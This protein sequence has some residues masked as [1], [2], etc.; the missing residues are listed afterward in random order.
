M[1]QFLIS[2]SICCLMAFCQ[3]ISADGGGKELPVGTN[4]VDW[5]LA[6]P[7]NALGPIPSNAAWRQDGDAFLGEGSAA[8]WS[9][10]LAGD[11]NWNDYELSADVTI[12]RQAPKADFPMHRGEFDRYLP[13]DWFPPNCEHTGQFRYRY[14][15]GEFDPGS[16]AAVFVRYRNREQCYRIQLST[17]YGEVVLWHGIGGYLAVVPYDLEQ[18]RPY[19]VKVRAAGR[20]LQVSIDGNDVIDYVHHT[21]PAI[22]GK[23]GFGVYN[24]AAS[25]ENITVAEIEPEQGTPPPHRPDFRVRDWRGMRWIFD[26]PEPICAMEKDIA[27]S[28]YEGLLVLSHIKSLP[29]YRPQ[30]KT[31]IGVHPYPEG[32]SSTSRLVGDLAGI[33]TKTEPNRLIL[34]F[35]TAH[36]EGILSTAHRD[37]LTY[38]AKRGTY[39]HDFLCD[40]TF[41]KDCRATTIEFLDPLTHNNKFPAP[42]VKHRWLPSGHEWGLFRSENGAICRHPVSQALHLPGQNTW[43]ASAENGFWML[44]PDRAAA[45][46]W[47]FSVPGTSVRIEV[48]HWG[49][50]FHQ[51]MVPTNS[52]FRAGDSLS[53]RFAL[54]AYPTNEADRIF[55]ESALSPQNNSYAAP[56]KPSPRTAPD[57]FALPIC[58]PSGTDFRVAETIR[59]PFVGWPFMGSYKLDSAVGRDDKNS[60]RLD[61]PGVLRGEFYHHMIDSRPGPYRFTIWIKTRGCSAAP[62]IELKYPYAKDGPADTVDTALSGD[63]DWQE[64][65]F[66]TY[67]PSLTPRTYDSTE[68]WLRLDGEGSVWIDDFSV[69]PVDEGEDSSDRLP[70]GATLTR[71]KP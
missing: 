18:G 54:T 15:A 50:D 71:W 43:E 3:I 58:D 46:V 39:R 26:G 40:V 13:R 66:I 29:G 5:S 11:E 23:V 55:R 8:P 45:P 68:I 24:A 9:I 10:R 30:Y 31:W 35:A 14:F 32:A 2:F 17:E 27:P 69:R 34:E 41:L 20:R 25:F 38:D 65:S 53:L 47:E 62:I 7:V 44:Y 70:K 28:P 16:D 56:A 42:G 51:R 60:L 64:I 6:E 4:L 52:S 19:N 1:K 12:R 48:C 49:Y 59:A 33:G 21:L 36:P 61:G 22:R 37:T 63:N 57:G 67:V